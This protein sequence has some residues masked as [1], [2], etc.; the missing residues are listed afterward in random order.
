MLFPAGPTTERTACM[1]IAHLVPLI[2]SR[3]NRCFF[4]NKCLHL[5]IACSHKCSRHSAQV[6][7]FISLVDVICFHFME[8]LGSQDH[9]RLGHQCQLKLGRQRLTASLSTPQDS[10]AGYLGKIML[11]VWMFLKNFRE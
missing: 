7:S 6:D 10:Q 8:C 11:L 3:G 9:S 4:C 2:D 5:H 1:Q